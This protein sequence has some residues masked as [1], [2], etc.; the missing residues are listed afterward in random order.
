MKDGE[1][2]YVFS[3]VNGKQT[4]MSEGKITKKIAHGKYM[5]LQTDAH[6]QPGLAAVDYLMSMVI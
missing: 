3:A 6:M 1:K 5:M 4:G 2:V